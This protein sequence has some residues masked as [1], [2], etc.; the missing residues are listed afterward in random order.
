MGIKNI[1]NR[2]LSK[3]KKIVI[4]GLDYAGKTTMV[5][6]LQ[7]GTFIEH[8]PTMGKEQTTIEVQGVRMELV[9]MGGQRDFR[10]LW[11]G[12]LKD[13]SF[14]IF[15]VDAAD[16][17]RFDEAKEELWKLASLIEEK[18][19]IVLAN[20]YDKTDVASIKDIID[21][22]N[23]SELSSFEI[24]PISC[25]TGFGIVKAFRKI[26]Y[27]L[28]GKQ[29]TKRMKPKALTIFD[30]GGVPLTSTSYDDVLKGGLFS[31]ICSFVKESFQKE[32]N[33]LKLEGNTII[34][35]RSDHLMGSIVLDDGENV[36]INEAEDGL[37]EL[38]N[39]LEHMCPE[40]EKEELDQEKLKFLVEQYATN[41]LE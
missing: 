5:S 31:A 7:T 17:D 6:F 35:K 12:E 39:H 34:F 37:E 30:K 11:R 23:L 15:M 41:L 20:K 1:I 29:L 8:T 38:L 3:E 14:V 9:D 28:T 36:S 32:L 18:P 4:T 27:R 40:L 22:L 10:S 13:A 2:I 33:R 21:A 19:L 16:R 26:Y 24:I 25:K